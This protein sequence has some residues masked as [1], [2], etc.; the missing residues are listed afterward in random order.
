[1]KSSIYRVVIVKGGEITW[2][3]GK[4]FATEQSAINDIEQRTADDEK[5]LNYKVEKYNLHPWDYFEMNEAA[6]PVWLTV[7]LIT[8]VI[9]EKSGAKVTYGVVAYELN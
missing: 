1:M 3:N 5:L 9:N 8:N 4:F 2:A 7:H 6:T